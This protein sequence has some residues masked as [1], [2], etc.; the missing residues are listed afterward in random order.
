M[1]KEKGTFMK[2]EYILDLDKRELENALVEMG[3]PKYRGGQVFSWIYKGISDFSHMANIPKALRDKVAEKFSLRPMS[4]EGVQ[5]SKSDGTKKYLFRLPD[6]NAI[7]AV[8]MKYKYGNTL[9]VSSQAGCR[10]G[11]KFCA[12]TM[13]GLAR[14]LSSGEMIGEILEVERDTGEKINHIVVMGTGEP[15][16]NY[17]SVSKFIRT[18]NDKDGLNIG[19]RNITV[20]TC[21]IVPGI[22][23]FA[24]DFPQTNLAISL[25]AA[26]DE[27]RSMLMP[28]NKAYPLK[29]LLDGC[30]KYVNITSRRITFEYTLIKDKNDSREDGEMLIKLLKGLLCHVNLIPLNEV[31]ETG[32]KTPNREAAFE[33]QKQ[34]EAKGIPTTVRRELGDDIDGACGQLRLKSK[35]NA[36]AKSINNK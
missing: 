8:F 13:E 9:C 27:K 3:E 7:E 1:E 31:K 18:I 4:I 23:R 34:L 32:L 28:V 36:E 15:F 33:F 35:A 17:E 5:T 26:T 21:G 22:L 6:G 12:S 16:D 10:M 25:H 14:N 2:R 19:M 24:E 29:E 30:R 20:S 11:C